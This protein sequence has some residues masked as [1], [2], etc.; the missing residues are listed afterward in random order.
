MHTHLP[1]GRALNQPGLLL[2]A[3]LLLCH[4]VCLALA[5]PPWPL[6]CHP[7]RFPSVPPHCDPVCRAPPTPPCC[8]L[9]CAR[10][11]MAAVTTPPS[12]SWTRTPAGQCRW[13]CPRQHSRLRPSWRPGCEGHEE[14]WECGGDVL[15]LPSWCLGCP[16]CTLTRMAQHQVLHN[17]R[18]AM[19]M[20][21]KC[22][23]DIRSL[24]RASSPVSLLL[25]PMSG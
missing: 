21:T 17:R 8:G 4:P 13:Y 23:K 11:Q 22:R 15:A 9:L 2:I 18:Q 20:L 3:C 12:F 24:A 1:V 19:D 10:L 14:C 16:P 5:V 6:L 7:V 25:K